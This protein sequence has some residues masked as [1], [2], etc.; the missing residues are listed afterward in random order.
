MVVI[1]P[2][3]FVSRNKHLPASAFL[4]TT[5]RAPSEMSSARNGP[6]RA[7]KG[8][9]GGDGCRAW[10]GKLLGA[11][12]THRRDSSRQP[13]LGNT[14]PRAAEACHLRLG[15][16]CSP[17]SDT[18]LDLGSQ[19]ELTSRQCAESKQ[20]TPCIFEYIYLAR[21]DSVLNDIPVYNFQL[22]LGSRLA[23]RIKCAAQPSHFQRQSDFS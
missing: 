6:F 8:R 14:P 7:P 12:V 22:G 21:P 15:R 10:C 2:R 3:W 16:E 1:N 19:G 5:W 18:E 4:S 13:H 9:A 11:S 23:T 17:I 20:T